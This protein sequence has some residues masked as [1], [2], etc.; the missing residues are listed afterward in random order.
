MQDAADES[1]FAWTR[2]ASAGAVPAIPGVLSIPMPGVHMSFAVVSVL[3]V[4]GNSVAVKAAT[5]V[6]PAAVRRH[7]IATGTA[8][9]GAVL[10]ALAVWLARA[11]P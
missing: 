4:C 5:L 7:P 6:G 3:V 2:V 1:R 10:V 11:A 9:L 8:V